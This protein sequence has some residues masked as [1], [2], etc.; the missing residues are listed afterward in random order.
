MCSNARGLTIETIDGLDEQ[1]VGTGFIIIVQETLYLCA[2]K[3]S[4]RQVLDVLDKIYQ[5]DSAIVNR[6][7]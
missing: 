7:Y 2:H 3:L 6:R 1:C 4:L 5:F